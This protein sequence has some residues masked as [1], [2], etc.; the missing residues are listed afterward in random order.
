M[1]K[2]ELLALS[3]VHLTSEWVAQFGGE[4][5]RHQKNECSGFLDV[6]KLARGKEKQ[7]G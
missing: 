6:L 1:C 4:L 3:P 7:M 2:D 5:E